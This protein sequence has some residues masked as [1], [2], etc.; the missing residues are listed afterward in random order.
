MVAL[1]GATAPSRADAQQ[2]PPIFVGPAPIPSATTDRTVHLHVAEMEALTLETRVA[3]DRPWS[4]ICSTPCD[5]RLAADAE[6]RVGGEDFVPSEPFQ[7]TAV[8]GRNANLEVRPFSESR[9]HLAIAFV[10]IGPAAMITGAVMVSRSAEHPVLIEVGIPVALVG[11]L[12]FISG[13]VALPE[14][15]AVVV[16]PDEGRARGADV[17]LRLPVARE[18]SAIDVL[19]PRSL[20]FQLYARRFE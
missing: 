4:V 6:Y 12:T 17:E 10:V 13:L 20:T 15:T 2:T 11:L 7:L 5:A 9:R 19:W 1:L 3:A 8:A 18:A 14:R 16:R